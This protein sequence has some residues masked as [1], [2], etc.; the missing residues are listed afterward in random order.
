MPIPFYKPIDYEG[1]LCD[2]KPK[3]FDEG[4]YHIETSSLICAANQW[5]GS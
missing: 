4:P 1:D 2:W 3:L 5:T